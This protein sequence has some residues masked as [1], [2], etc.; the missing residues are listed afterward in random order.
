MAERVWSG[1]HPT[2]AALR[3]FANGKLPAEAEVAVEG[4][5]IFEC[6]AGHC[7]RVLHRFPNAIDALLRAAARRHRV[8]GRC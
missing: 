1:G 7:H 4:H 3:D 5:L 6:P 8:G 2:A